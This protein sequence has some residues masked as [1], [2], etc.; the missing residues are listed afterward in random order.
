[1]QLIPLT[2]MFYFPF[3]IYCTSI[4]HSLLNKSFIHLISILLKTISSFHLMAFSRSW[5]VYNTYPCTLHSTVHLCNAL[6]A[7]S[8]PA[9]TNHHTVIFFILYCTCLSVLYCT[10]YHLPTC[11]LYRFVLSEKIICGIYTIILQASQLFR[12]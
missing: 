12:M 5:L 11:I 4:L 8:F 9:I 7:F 1:M 2:I 3:P 6:V 10:I